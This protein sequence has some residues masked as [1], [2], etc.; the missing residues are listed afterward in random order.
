LLK[1]RSL[2]GAAFLFRIWSVES[3]Q[4]SLDRGWAGASLSKQVLKM[5]IRL[6]KRY[7]LREVL[8]ATIGA[9]FVFCLIMVA[10]NALRELAAR[11]ADGRLSVGTFFEML[12]LLIPYVVSFS[13]PLGLLCGILIGLGRLSANREITA[14]K[15]T[16]SSLWQL[17]SPILAFA[18][19]LA[20]LAFYTNT[21]FT[22]YA[23]ARYKSLMVEALRENPLRLFK[24]GVLSRDFPGYVFFLKEKEGNLLKGF[25]LWEL[26][27]SQ[28]PS[29]FI[30]ANEG[31][32]DYDRVS[33]SL[34][35]TLRDGMV[36]KWPDSGEDLVKSPPSALYYGEFPVKLPLSYSIGAGR[37]KRDLDECTLGEMLVMLRSDEAIPDEH[38]DHPEFF[39]QRIRVQ[40]SNYFA[41]AASL[42]AM[43]L[44]A[45]PL[46]IQTGRKESYANAALALGIGMVYYFCVSMLT[47]LTIPAVFQPALLVW[48][49]N[50]VLVVVGLMLMRR[51]HAH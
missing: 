38:R 27:S 23:R 26:D 8:V 11:L 49:P 4:S 36:E 51:V 43:S 48:L 25:W 31:R 40:I 33:D 41:M 24:E 17:A 28:R 50:L 5:P 32:I 7:I 18:S 44:I 42:L 19:L 39:R 35:L 37:K 21:S 14:M 1:S 20:V 6:L 3:F 46:A 45:I 16:G 13:L 34:I 22:P 2:T 30:R 15:A 12:A 9:L 29:L 10:G 47:T